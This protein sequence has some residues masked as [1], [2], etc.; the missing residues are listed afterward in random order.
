VPQRLSEAAFRLQKD[1]VQLDD[2]RQ[3]ATAVFSDKY[4][5]NFH[6]TVPI[7]DCHRPILDEEEEPLVWNAGAYYCSSWTR[8]SSLWA[9]FSTKLNCWPAGQSARQSAGMAN[10]A[11]AQIVRHKTN[12]LQSVFSLASSHSNFPMLTSRF[13]P[14]SYSIHLPWQFL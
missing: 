4:L 2:E 9:E 8:L 12:R 14:P 1:G 6:T 11:V 13:S 3:S 7:I 5:P 10:G